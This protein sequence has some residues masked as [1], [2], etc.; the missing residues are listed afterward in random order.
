[1]AHFLSRGA[2]SNMLIFLFLTLTVVVD[3][4]FANGQYERRKSAFAP[5]DPAIYSFHY[6][7]EDPKSGS[8][9]GHQVRSLTF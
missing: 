1:M 5:P 7:I 2:S 4:T 9:Y 8:N 6:A 3:K